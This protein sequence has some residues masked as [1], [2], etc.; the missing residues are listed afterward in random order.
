MIIGMQVPGVPQVFPAKVT[1][2]KENGDVTVDLNPPLAGQTLH[3]KIKLEAVGE[4]TEH[5]HSCGD[6]SCGDDGCDDEGCGDACACDSEPEVEE[7]APAEE[8]KK[9]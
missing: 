3:F 4:P 9:E 8:V 7:A 5:A 1:E 2:L 6:C